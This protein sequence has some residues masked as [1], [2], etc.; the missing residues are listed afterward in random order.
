VKGKHNRKTIPDEWELLDRR[1]RFWVKPGD[2]F[3]P[4]QA[5]KKAALEEKRGEH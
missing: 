3:C 1:D 5:F 2:R 4:S